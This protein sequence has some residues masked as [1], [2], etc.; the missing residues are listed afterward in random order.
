MAMVGDADSLGDRDP[1]VPPCAAAIAPYASAEP[2]GLVPLCLM[3]VRRDVFQIAESKWSQSCVIFCT[4]C[5]SLPF[6][7]RSLILACE[8][9]AFYFLGILLTGRQT[10]ICFSVTQ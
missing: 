3:A 2:A 5:F 9:L 6:L 1:V 10:E 4:R 8:Q 7:H